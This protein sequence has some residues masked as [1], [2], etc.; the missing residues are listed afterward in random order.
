MVDTQVPGQRGQE[1]QSCVRCFLQVL[2]VTP[3]PA[4]RPDSLCVP[5]AS[6]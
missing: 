6:K 4:L 3:Q 2:F 5:M 1:Q